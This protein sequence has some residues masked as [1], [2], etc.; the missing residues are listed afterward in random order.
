MY[1]ACHCRILGL[2]VA[3]FL[4]RITKEFIHC[5]IRD[6]DTFP[7]HSLCNFSFLVLSWIKI[8]LL[9]KTKNCRKQINYSM[10]VA[11]PFE[12]SHRKKNQVFQKFFSDVWVVLPFF[13]RTIGHVLLRISEKSLKM[14]SLV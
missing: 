2:Y 14:Y 11:Y 1:H 7:L 12:I 9:L 8:K 4:H 3:G 5:R 6:D 10:Y 13:K